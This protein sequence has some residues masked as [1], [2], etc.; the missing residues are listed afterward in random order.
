MIFFSFIKSFLWIWYE[1][2]HFTEFNAQ[3]P[4][5]THVASSKN[6]MNWYKY[7]QTV[8]GMHANYFRYITM[9]FGYVLIFYFH[10]SMRI[11]WFWLLL[12]RGKKVPLTVRRVLSVYFD[13][14]AHLHTTIQNSSFGSFAF[15]LCFPWCWMR[16]G[17]L[18]V[19]F[20]LSIEANLFKLD[21]FD[22][23]GETLKLSMSLTFLFRHCRNTFNIAWVC[24]FYTT[25]DIYWRDHEVSHSQGFLKTFMCMIYWNS[26]DVKYKW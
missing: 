4:L 12:R 14:R 15:Y 11:I 6:T 18:S 20:I 19:D 26:F 16:I 22:F 5:T 24:W 25:R 17:H 23:F 13:M 3:Q 2:F 9:C 7:T 8:H 1:K 21:L 10:I